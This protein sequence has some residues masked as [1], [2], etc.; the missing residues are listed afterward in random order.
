MAVYMFASGDRRHALACV[1]GERVEGP[2]SIGAQPCVEYDDLSAQAKLDLSRL[3]R[4]TPR[5]TGREPDYQATL[6]M[7]VTT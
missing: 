1:L 7:M 6:A 5:F 3:S 2:E 4:S